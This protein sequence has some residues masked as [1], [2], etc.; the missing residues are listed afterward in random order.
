MIYVIFSLILTFSFYSYGVDI[1][2]YGRVYKIAEKDM[3]EEMMEKAK[4]I[5]Y[6]KIR[7][8]V[9]NYIL[10]YKPKDLPHLTRAKKSYIYYV[11]YVY[12]LPEDIKIP[13]KDGFK[14]LYKKGYKF[15]PIK[16]LRYKPVDL[17]IFNGNDIHEILFV[18]KHFIDKKIR[19]RLVLSDGNYRKVVKKLNVPVYYAYGKYF[20]R[21]KLRNTVS[22]VTVDINKGKFLITVYAVDKEGNLKD[23]D[24]Y[25]L[26][27]N[28]YLRKKESVKVK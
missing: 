10:N 1:G 22:R 7:E 26:D 14:V 23:D 18:K 2:T 17:L 9:K 6:K 4:K 5:D 15:R 16:Y 21:F 8:K 13:T 27:E 25:Y 20:S 3:L 28:S 24:K 19:V 12:E 11:D